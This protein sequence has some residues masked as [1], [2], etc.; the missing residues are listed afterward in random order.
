MLLTRHVLQVEASMFTFEEASHLMGE[1]IPTLLERKTAVQVFSGFTEL[2]S[3]VSTGSSAP[4]H[5]SWLNRI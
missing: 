3:W 5:M 1:D 4:K 2:A